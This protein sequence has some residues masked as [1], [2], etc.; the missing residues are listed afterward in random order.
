MRGVMEANDV[1]FKN[2]ND[3]QIVLLRRMLGWCQSLAVVR[4]DYARK[5]TGESL[6]SLWRDFEK[7]SKK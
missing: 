6:E 1:D 3:E 5:T 2:L 4:N 7:A